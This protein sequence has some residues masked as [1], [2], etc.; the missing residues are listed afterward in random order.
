MK[1]RLV[2]LCII[3]SMLLCACSTQKFF[4]GDTSGTTFNQDKRKAVYLFWGII[5]FGR[6]QN[7]VIYPEAKGYSIITRFN[8]IDMIVT[9]LTGGVILMKTIKYEP[10][11]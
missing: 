7:F 2:T 6:K 8:G 11:K 1:T 5:C 9:S 10:K 3:V 4:V